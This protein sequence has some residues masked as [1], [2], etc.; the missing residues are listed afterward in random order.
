MNGGKL[1]V[2]C[3]LL[4]RDFKKWYQYIVDGAKI[5]RRLT[6]SLLPRARRERREPEILFILC[7]LLYTSGGGSAIM[8]LYEQILCWVGILRCKGNVLLLLRRIRMG[9]RAASNRG[10]MKRGYGQRRVNPCYQ[11]AMGMDR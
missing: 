8:L 7:E 11:D 1:G 10:I 2:A 9:F 4:Q 5:L 6:L 3:G